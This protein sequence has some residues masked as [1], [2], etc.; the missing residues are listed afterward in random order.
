[1]RKI[2]KI[3]IHCSDWEHTGYQF[4][5][6]KKWHIDKGWDDIGYHFVIEKDGTVKKGRD[7]DVVGAHCRKHNVD[8]IGVCLAGRRMTDFMPIQ[9]QVMQQLVRNLCAVFK[10]IEEVSPHSAYNDS[11]TCP[12]FEIVIIGAD[13]VITYIDESSELLSNSFLGN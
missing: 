2:K 11:K 6:I 7:L 8:S 1:M 3:I 5:E 9:F 4:D 10:D 13:N 12:N